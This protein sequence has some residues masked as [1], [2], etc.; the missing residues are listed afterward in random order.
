VKAKD[1]S[2]PAMGQTPKTPRCGTRFEALGEILTINFDP[3]LHLFLFGGHDRRD[4]AQ[5]LPFSKISFILFNKIAEKYK[6]LK[7]MK[8]SAKIDKKQKSLNFVMLD[9]SFQ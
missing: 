5:P 7:T 9:Q 3:C 1:V 6:K 8:F 2:Q 4:R